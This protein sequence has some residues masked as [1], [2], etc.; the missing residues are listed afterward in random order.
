[1][2]RVAPTGLECRTSER[3][4]AAASELG[5]VTRR[6]RSTID[7]LAA[8]GLR[9]GEEN[10]F[11]GNRRPRHLSGSVDRSDAAADH[12]RRQRDASHQHLLPLDHDGADYTPA[13]VAEVAT[14]R[15]AALRPAS[16]ALNPA[17]PQFITKT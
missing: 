15:P 2:A 1:D 16:T 10:S 4:R 11:G 13:R 7:G 8:R 9:F 14:Y 5:A 3:R 12:R 6:A 17:S